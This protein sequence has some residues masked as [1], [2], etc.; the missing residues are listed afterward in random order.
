MDDAERDY[1]INN[2]DVGETPFRG[3]TGGRKECPICGHKVKEH[4]KKSSVFG[5]K[6]ICEVCG[7]KTKHKEFFAI[8]DRLYPTKAMINNCGECEHKKKDHSIELHEIR[9][10]K[11]ACDICSCKIDID[12]EPNFSACH[13]ANDIIRQ[14]RDLSRQLDPY[15]GTVY[16]SRHLKD[17]RFAVLWDGVKIFTN[18][19]GHRQKFTYRDEMGNPF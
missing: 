14:L 13:N 2:P 16:E 3:K 9:S 4:Y 18:P 1:F 11:I 12:Y 8:L 17:Y 19:H 7:C 10:T 6:V 15:S 5:T